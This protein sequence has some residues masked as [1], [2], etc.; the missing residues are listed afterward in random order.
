MSPR[1]GSR[2]V[3]A[4]L[5]GL[6]VVAGIARGQDPETPAPE[7]D[8]NER[9][10]VRIEEHRESLSLALFAAA[11]ENGDDRLDLFETAHAL[12]SVSLPL[13]G[14]SLATFRSIDLDRSGAIEW[15][16]FDRRYLGVFRATSRFELELRGEIVEPDD[17]TEPRPAKR[18]DGVAPGKTG[19]LARLVDIDNDGRVSVEELARLIEALGLFGADPAQT[20]LLLDADRSGDIDLFEILP[21]LDRPDVVQILE[22]RSVV[23]A[24]RTSLPEGQR[25]ADVNGDG[26]LD[27]LEL[28]GALRL[29]DPLLA[30]HADR[31]LQHADRNR[32]GTLGLVELVPPKPA[33]PATPTEPAPS[34]RDGR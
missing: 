18:Q 25:A 15:P 16:E 28:A 21:L 7:K 3:V 12:P 9:R 34:R 14:D 11:D 27:R 29:L 13:I 24:R 6:S 1:A 10:L 26:V 4:A 23:A 17:P 32:N 22:N 5:V 33:E 8:P 19:R 2:P 30:R 20:K 31:I